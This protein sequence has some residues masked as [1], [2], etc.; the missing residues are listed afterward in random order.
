MVGGL[1]G[2]VGLGFDGF[3]SA[4]DHLLD[5]G[6]FVD[7]AD[8]IGCNEL[9]VAEDGDAVAAGEDFAHAVGDIDD[10]EALGGEVAGDV[11][12]YRG[13]GD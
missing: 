9:A 8:D 12:Q 4:A 6:G 10:G 3:D 1:V 11:H 7:V 5:E 2:T 13:L